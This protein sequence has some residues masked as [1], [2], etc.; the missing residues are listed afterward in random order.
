M[1]K[2]TSALRLSAFAKTLSELCEEKKLLLLCSIDF[3]HYQS[4]LLAEK[5][6]EK[7]IR[8]VEDGD[9]TALLQM[10][11]KYLDSPESLVLLL[12]L[13]RL[14][15]CSIQLTDRDTLYYTEEGALSAATY[16]V[17]TLSRPPCEK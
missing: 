3:S 17:Y 6:D 13:A 9:L 8:A 1:G 15:G 14:K 12:E 4:P 11:G 7:T 5:Y 16:M 10:D 2:G